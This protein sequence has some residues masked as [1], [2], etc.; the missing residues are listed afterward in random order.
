M[1]HPFRMSVSNIDRYSDHEWI[2]FR[3]NLKQGYD[4][5]EATTGTGVSGKRYVSDPTPIPVADD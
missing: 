4:A 3:R 2:D 1:P 5:F